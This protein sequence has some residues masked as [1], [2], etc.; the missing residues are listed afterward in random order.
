MLAR[1]ALPA[2]FVAWNGRTGAP[3]FGP[4]SQYVAGR[5]TRVWEYPWAFSATTLAS[6]DRAL[7]VGGLNSGFAV[8]LAKHGLDVTVVDP[9]VE[10]NAP[11]EVVE[12]WARHWGTRIRA[13]RSTADAL[14]EPD[15][16]FDAAFC[17]SVLEHVAHAADRRAL[18]M[19]V[20]RLL[21]PGGHFVLTVDLCVRLAP[22]APAECWGNLR[23]VRI[24]E[25]IG[26]YELVG[27]IPHELLGMPGFRLP[28]DLLLTDAGLTSQCFVLRKPRE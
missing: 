2:A 21:R 8:T 19:G 28:P 15:G 14:D 9:D 24:D 26:P 5:S 7:D 23:N 12:A 11:A 4:Y 6:G 1:A 18:M 17:L 3:Y 13:R 27:G 10:G 25:L 20:F 22:F 16:S